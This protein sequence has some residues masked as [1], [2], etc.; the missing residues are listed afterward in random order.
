MANELVTYN[1]LRVQVS[2]EALQLLHCNKLSK[3]LQSQKNGTNAINNL[4]IINNTN[5]F[6]SLSVP[7]SSCSWYQIL[8]LQNIGASIKCNIFSNTEQFIDVRKIKKIK[9]RTEKVK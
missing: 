8:C 4:L 6:I 1:W 3:Q 7:V 2:I 9:N 5:F